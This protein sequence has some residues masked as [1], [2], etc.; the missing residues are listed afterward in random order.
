MSD[1]TDF[2]ASLRRLILATRKAELGDVDLGA[3][4]AL[5]DDLAAGL[6]ARAVPGVRMQAGLTI[7]AVAARLEGSDGSRLERGVAGGIAGFFPYSPYVGALNPIAP[8]VA[9]GVKPAAGWAEVHGEHTFADVYNGPPGG[10]HGGVVA[11]VF[12]E[13]LGSVCVV[14][15]VAG[16]TGTLSVRYS[17]LTPLDEP[18]RIRGWVERVDGRKTF[19]RGTF[20]HGDTLTAE[21]EGVFI[22]A[23]PGGGTLPEV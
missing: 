19:A 5:L 16:F 3:E 14:N 10:V 4:A 12:D 1:P 22:S 20:H 6:E 8:P 2:V 15:D 7:D 21:A 23:R 11:G 17:S 18:I 9:L 13:V